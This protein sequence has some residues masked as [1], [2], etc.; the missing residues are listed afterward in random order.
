MRPSSCLPERPA[1]A[2]FRDHLDL[3]YAGA[4][5]E[6]GLAYNVFE[7][8]MIGYFN[9]LADSLILRESIITI[10]DYTLPS[11]KEAP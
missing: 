6:D 3:L 2:A 4:G 1:Y 10:I 9:M 7:L 5:L 8:A 11:T